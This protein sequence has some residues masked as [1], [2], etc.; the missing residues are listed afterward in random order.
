MH[1]ARTDDSAREVRPSWVDETTAD[2]TCAATAAVAPATVG[3]PCSITESSSTRR[4]T[5][6]HQTILDGHTQSQ[7]P[8]R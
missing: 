4:A 8:Y 2:T 5:S 7:S 3:A 6:R 1:P